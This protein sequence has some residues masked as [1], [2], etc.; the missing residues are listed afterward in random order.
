MRSRSALTVP[1]GNAT[2]GGEKN[3][4][5]WSIEHALYVFSA[6]KCYKQKRV[7]LGYEKNNATLY[8]VPMSDTNDR[9]R[10]SV[11]KALHFVFKM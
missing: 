3:D 2:A 4:V 8:F 1:S 7:R 6:G 9:K 11:S 5:F 10:V